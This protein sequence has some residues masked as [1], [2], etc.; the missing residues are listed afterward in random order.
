MSYNGVGLQSVRGSGTSGYVQRNLSVPKPRRRLELMH[1]QIAAP[2]PAYKKPNADILQ[3]AAKR[4][5]ELKLME[6]RLLMEE[7]GYGETEILEK[8]G[9]ARSGLLVAGGQ[10]DAAAP[11]EATGT[12]GM[13]VLKKAEDERMRDAFGISSAY[14]EGSSFDV[15]VQM[16]R[17]AEAQAARE[18][19]D[20]KWKAD[21]AA[22]AAL[23][24]ARE[25][26]RAARESQ[27]RS[28]GLDRRDATGSSSQKRGSGGA[29][30]GAPRRRSWSRSRSPPVAAGARS[31]L[32]RERYSRRPSPS[33]PPR[34]AA[35]GRGERRQARSRASRSSSASSKGSSSRSRSSSEHS[36]RS[37]SASV[38]SR[39]P[40]PQPRRSR[41]RD[42][43]GLGAKG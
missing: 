23:R 42:A 39:S 2:E 18:A 9:E 7:Q 10:S 1:D 25:E 27:H 14:K 16:Q 5:V 20:A 30:T 41:S 8:L 11:S 28:T 35:G 31:E 29:A 40:P 4:T 19:A 17:K 33:P 3:H 12:H 36:S 13:S 43:D 6:L 37:N 26:E 38:S 34:S 15:E 22:R 32:H 24:A 21:Q